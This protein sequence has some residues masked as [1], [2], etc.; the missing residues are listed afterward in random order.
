MGIDVDWLQVTTTA[1]GSGF[2]VAVVNMLIEWFR[3]TRKTAQ[4]KKFLAVQIAT[5]LEGYAFNAFNAYTDHGEKEISSGQVGKWL[6]E[7]KQLPTLPPID[8]YELLSAG[9]LDR[10]FQ[11]PQQRIMFERD[12]YGGVDFSEDT[13]EFWAKMLR[14]QLE[15][16]HLSLGIAKDLRREAGLPKRPLRL[17]NWDIEKTL[18]AEIEKRNVFPLVF[19]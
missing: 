6:E 8:G 13:D 3:T 9:L 16:I 1:L 2:V 11:L 14:R 10:I 15:L 18:A 12:A 4:V 17:D 19:R 5:L 7:L